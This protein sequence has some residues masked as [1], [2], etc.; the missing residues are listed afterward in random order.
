M[1]Y[2]WGMSSIQVEPCGLR[3]CVLKVE[4]LSPDQ[5]RLYARAKT[6]SLLSAVARWRIDDPVQFDELFDAVSG[7]AAAPQFEGLTSNLVVKES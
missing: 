7:F 5:V 2:P 1:M 6:G 4:Y 3:E